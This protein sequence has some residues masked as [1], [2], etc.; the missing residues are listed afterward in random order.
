MQ[1]LFETKIA[2]YDLAMVSLFLY[3]L[4]TQLKDKKIDLIWIQLHHKHKQ[5]S[6]PLFYL[7]AG[8]RIRIGSGFGI[9][10]RIQEGKNDPQNMKKV[11]KFQVLKFS[12]EGWR[13][14]L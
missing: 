5:S 2:K 11:K 12:F 1:V 9:R 8:F 13:L 7:R 4:T 10:I 6:F 14:L 3:V